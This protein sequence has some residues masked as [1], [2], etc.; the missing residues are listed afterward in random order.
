MAI[1]PKWRRP[2]QSEG[3]YAKAKAIMLV[4]TARQQLLHCSVVFR[5]S[6]PCGSSSLFVSGPHE[7]YFY[8]YFDYYPDAWD[9]GNYFTK[10][11][12]NIGGF[13]GSFRQTACRDHPTPTVKVLA[14]GYKALMPLCALNVTSHHCSPRWSNNKWWCHKG[15]WDAE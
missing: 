13:C 11:L 5:S 9:L 1:M 6:F 7:Y 8:Y 2:C 4:T 14:L 12:R 10:H 15:S 3:N